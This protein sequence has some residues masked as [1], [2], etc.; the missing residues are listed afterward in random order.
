VRPCGFREARTWQKEQYVSVWQLKQPA[1]P[2]F[3]TTPGCCCG[4]PTLAT[5]QAVPGL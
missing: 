5:P 4:V 2:C 1:V 3:F